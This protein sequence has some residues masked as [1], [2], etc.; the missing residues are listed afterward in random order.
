MIL[1]WVWLRAVILGGES[2][3]PIWVFLPLLQHLLLSFFFFFFQ[4]QFD[5][6]Y[7]F[8]YGFDEFGSRF[9]TILMILWCLRD[10]FRLGFP[11]SFD[12]FWVRFSNYFSV[13]FGLIFCARL[14][15]LVVVVG[16]LFSA[17]FFL[18]SRTGLLYTLGEGIFVKVLWEHFLSSLFLS[19]WEDEFCGRGNTKHHHRQAI[20]TQYQLNT[21]T[22]KC[23]PP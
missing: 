3:I 17:S 12:W 14:R 15:Y 1:S 4:F 7:E 6:L 22:V 20:Q 18:F 23:T 8:V 11:V 19:I 2:K 16:W 5:Y 9:R 21:N 13:D 10:D